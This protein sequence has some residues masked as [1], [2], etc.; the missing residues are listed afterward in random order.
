MADSNLRRIYMEISS[1]TVREKMAILS[2]LIAEVSSAAER[3]EGQDIY[4]LKGLGKEIWKG[5]DAQE[6]VDAE[7][8]SWE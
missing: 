8:A 2:K 1:L 4:S 3:N 7:R 6:Y 5:I